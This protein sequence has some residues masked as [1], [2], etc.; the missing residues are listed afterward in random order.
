MQSPEIL[1]VI[2][3]MPDARDL[4]NALYNCNYRVFMRSLMKVYDALQRDRY[5]ASHADFY[6]REMR[7]KGY[8]QFLDSYKSVTM[9]SMARAFGIG[10]DALDTCV[11]HFPLFLRWFVLMFI[12][13]VCAV[14]CRVSLPRTG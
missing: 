13:R 3:E 12:V 9:A 6:C 11:A 8:T 7:I 5:M 2:D 14:S 1:A 10:T 4:M